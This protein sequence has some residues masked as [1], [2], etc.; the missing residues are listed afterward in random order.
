[1]I[2]GRHYGYVI[3][4]GHGV[5]PGDTDEGEL[6]RRCAS[7]CRGVSRRCYLRR[8]EPVQK[9]EVGEELPYLED[10]KGKK[11]KYSM[12]VGSLI[13]RFLSLAKK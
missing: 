8:Q 13:P 2:G 5:E 10:N 11:Y 7:K 3:S 1:M 12:E 9:N 6:A 4:R